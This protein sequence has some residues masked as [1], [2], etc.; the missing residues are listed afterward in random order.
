MNLVGTR[1][2]ISPPFPTTPTTRRRSSPCATPCPR[3]PPSPC[4]TSRRRAIPSFPPSTI[5]TGASSP[6]RA[7]RRVQGLVV[8]SCPPGHHGKPKHRCSPTTTSLP[9]ERAFTSELRLQGDVI[10]H[11]VALE[12]RH[13]LLPRA[14]LSLLLGGCAVLQQDFRPREAIALM[15]AEG[16]T[17][18]M[19]ATPVYLRHAE[20]VDAEKAWPSTPCGCS[21]AAARLPPAAHRVR[22]RYDVLLCEIYGSDGKLPAC[23]RSCREAAPNGTA[24]GRAC[25]SRASRLGVIDENGRG[26]LPRQG[27]EI[28]RGPAMFAGYPN[29]RDR[30]DRAPGR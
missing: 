19:S 20:R 11:A 9:S 15:N 23:V 2:Y 4:W 5:S 1:A 18:S 8:A 10:V 13:R 17:L 22:A 29:E 16:V 12:P 21:A 27:E 6:C 30:T 24:P 7:R 28:S 14:H 3:L 25:P 26:A